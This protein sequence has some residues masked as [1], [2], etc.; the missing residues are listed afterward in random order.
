M[1]WIQCFSTNIAVVSCAK[2]EVVIELIG[3]LNLII[4]A[5]DAIRILTQCYMTT[6]LDKKPLQPLPYNGAALNF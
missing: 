1:D 6:S 5:K 2:R 4:K 3:H